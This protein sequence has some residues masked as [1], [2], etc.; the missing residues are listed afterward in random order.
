MRHTMRA[1]TC[2]YRNV[3]VHSVLSSR[4]N[5]PASTFMYQSSLKFDLGIK[6]A[7][8]AHL[9][10]TH[11]EMVST[12]AFLAPPLLL[13]IV[14]TSLAAPLLLSIVLTSLAAPLLLSVVLTSLAAP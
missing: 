4:T 1:D 2:V 11:G 5:E 3:H 10:M 12:S 8:I 14:L 9:W 7:G 13:S 6:A